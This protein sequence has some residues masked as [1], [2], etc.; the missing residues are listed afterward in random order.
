M[1]LCTYYGSIKL[2][3]KAMYMKQDQNHPPHYIVFTRI[4]YLKLQ[5]ITFGALAVNKN[6]C[7]HLAEEHCSR[8]YVSLFMSMTNHAGTGLHHSGF[9]QYQ[10]E[11][12]TYYTCTVVIQ[13][14]P[15]TRFGKLIHVLSYYIYIF[16]TFWTIKK[17]LIDISQPIITFYPAVLL[18]VWLQY[19][20]FIY[21]TYIP[22][23][24]VD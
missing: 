15:K 6:N 19:S 8:N 16:C 12:K 3:T 7:M 11:Y 5:S 23:C 24:V 18:W 20:N 21:S 17:T 13:D 4:G 1:F 10:S 22:F 9:H 2:H 14:K